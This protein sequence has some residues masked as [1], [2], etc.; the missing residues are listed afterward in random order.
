MIENGV[1]FYHWAEHFEGSVEKRLRR[2]QTPT[3]TRMVAVLLLRMA[4]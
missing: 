1:Y 2:P 3:L 4:I